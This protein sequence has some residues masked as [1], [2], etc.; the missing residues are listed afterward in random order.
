MAT[1]TDKILEIISKSLARN[2]KFSLSVVIPNIGLQIDSKLISYYVKSASLPSMTLNL[3]EQRHLGILKYAVH[4]TVVDTVNVTFYDTKEQK[5]R[6]MWTQYLKTTSSNGKYSALK[7]YPSEY[8]TTANLIVD[9]TNWKLEGISPIVVSDFV[10]D[11][12]VNDQLGTFDV[13]FKV[14]DVI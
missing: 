7:Y 12:D 11:Y 4:N 9:K 13:I 3:I 14:K 6:K 8:Q 5:L 10:L 1:D 2:N